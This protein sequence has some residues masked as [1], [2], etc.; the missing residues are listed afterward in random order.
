MAELETGRMAARIE[1][2]RGVQA[3]IGQ[4]LAG[5]RRIGHPQPVHDGPDRHVYRPGVV[6]DHD[7]LR[8]AEQSGQQGVQ[9]PVVAG[10][11]LQRRLRAFLGAGI[12]LVGEVVEHVLEDLNRQLVEVRSESGDG[13]RSVRPRREAH[14]C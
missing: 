11:R 12:S 8:L 1:E 10:P 7:T 5:R 4:H 2:L 9:V 13:A 14:Q 6:A 3:R